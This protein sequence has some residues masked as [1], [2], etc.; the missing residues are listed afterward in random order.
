MP[1]HNTQKIMSGHSK[2]ATIRRAKAV[3]DAKKGKLFS[4]LSRDIILAAKAGADL[5]TNFTLRLAVDRAKA[6]NMPADNIERAINKGSGQDKDSAAIQMITY[7]GL[8]PGGVALLIDCQT[9]NTNRAITE[10]R[11][12]MERFGGKLAPANSISW[13]FMEVGQVYVLAQKYIPGS[14]HGLA[15]GYVATSVDELEMQLIEQEGIKDIV[16][17]EGGFWVYTERAKFRDIHAWLDSMGY[18][19]EN[20]ELIKHAVEKQQISALDEE[21]LQGLVFALEECDDVVSVWHN[22]AD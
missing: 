11:M 12:I 9:D 2:W 19:V 14:K 17:E 22:A 8:G 16:A 4:K 7:E 5:E 3:T 20:A 21:K 18:K 15:G 6:A 13:R 1:V 10:V